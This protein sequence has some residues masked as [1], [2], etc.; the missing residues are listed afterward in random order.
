MANETPIPVQEFILAVKQKFPSLTNS[1]KLA[2]D[3]T[4]QLFEM[5]AS[6]FHLHIG[7]SGPIFGNRTIQHTYLAAIYY[8]DAEGGRH[9]IYSKMGHDRDEVLA[10]LHRFITNFFTELS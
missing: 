10:A 5:E 6:S 1:G 4:H 2:W 3:P 9:A 7:G 8:F